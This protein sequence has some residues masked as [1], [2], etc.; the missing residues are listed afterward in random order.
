MNKEFVKRFSLVKDILM[1]VCLIMLMLTPFGNKPAFGFMWHLTSWHMLFGCILTVL[2][3]THIILN[4]KWLTG[5]CKAWGKA[6]TA[7]RVKFFMMILVLLTMGASLTTGIMWGLGLGVGGFNNSTIIGNAIDLGDFPIRFWHAL[8]SW[9]A[10]YLTGIH[11]G[12]HLTKFLSFVAK[13]KPAA[14]KPAA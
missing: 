1:F 7:T 2:F 5:T 6:N 4:I 3:V 8:T 14:P 10:F 9:A 12:L 13:K 11:V